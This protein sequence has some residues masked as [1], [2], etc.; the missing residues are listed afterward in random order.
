MRSLIALIHYGE[1]YNRV[2]AR[3][4][5]IRG[6][7][8][9]WCDAMW[10][11]IMKFLL[12][13]HMNNNKYLIQVESHKKMLHRIIMILKWYKSNNMVIIMKQNQLWY[14]IITLTIM[15][16]FI[17]LLC[18]QY[19]SWRLYLQATSLPLHDPHE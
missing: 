4:G 18:A 12:P 14:N 11:D 17:Y 10:Y 13:S 7:M 8:M 16:N 5:Q 6:D 15:N 2:Q 3:R 19:S 9:M 1:K